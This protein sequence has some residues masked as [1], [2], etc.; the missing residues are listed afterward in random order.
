MTGLLTSGVNITSEVNGLQYSC[1]RIMVGLSLSRSGFLLYP[2]G[3][4][5]YS[6]RGESIASPRRRPRFGVAL[7]N[8]NHP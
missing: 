2:F 8:G 5:F 1:R 7:G 6:E 4:H 3:F